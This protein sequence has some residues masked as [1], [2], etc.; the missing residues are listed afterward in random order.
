M[1]IF[2]LDIIKTII[3]NIFIYLIYILNILIKRKRNI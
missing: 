1:S 2:I 3:Y